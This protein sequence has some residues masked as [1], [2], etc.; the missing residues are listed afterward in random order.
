M[1]NQTDDS[2]PALMEFTVWG[3]TTNKNAIKSYDPFSEAPENGIL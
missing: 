1:R 2:S 3:E